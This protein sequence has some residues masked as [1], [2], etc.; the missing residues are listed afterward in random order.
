M[1]PFPN[2]QHFDLVSLTG[3]LLSSSYVPEAG[4][5][6]HEEMLAALNGL[7]EAHQKEGHV[8]FDYDTVSYY[9]HLA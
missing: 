2:H 9:G 8:T 5:P 4:Q 7:F 1:K 3:R 6:R